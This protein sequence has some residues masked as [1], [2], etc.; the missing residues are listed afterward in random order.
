MSDLFDNVPT[1]AKSPQKMPFAV[2]RPKPVQAKDSV[3]G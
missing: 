3:N 1:P 2:V